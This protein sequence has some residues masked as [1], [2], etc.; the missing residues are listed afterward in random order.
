M[1]AE[2]VIKVLNENQGV[3]TAISIIGGLIGGLIFWLFKRRRDEA[4]KGKSQS[5]TIIGSHNY[6]EGQSLDNKIE[7]EQTSGCKLNKGSSGSH[8]VAKI[9]A[10]KNRIL[11]DCFLLECF[12][13]YFVISLDDLKDVLE[14]VASDTKKS[15]PRSPG[16]ILAFKK[17]YSFI[18]NSLTI[19]YNNNFYSVLGTELRQRSIVLE[20]R[21]NEEAFFKLPFQELSEDDFNISH[22][23]FS[24]YLNKES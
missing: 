18:P 3:L 17:F 15:Q 22:N 4:N 11:E 20:I 12:E 23:C 8:V 9:T 24:A 6:V 5:I 14:R 21:T 16:V 13:R 2:E 19:S 7:I 10:S 1:K